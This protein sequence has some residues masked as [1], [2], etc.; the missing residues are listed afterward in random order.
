MGAVRYDIKQG[1]IDDLMTVSQDTGY[2]TS[3]LNAVTIEK[4]PSDIKEHQTPLV[5]VLDDEREIK[6]VQA[7]GQRLYTWDL[8]LTCWVKTNKAADV[9]EELENLIDSV[10]EWTRNVVL[11]DIHSKVLDIKFNKI[12]GV[13][14]EDRLKLGGAHLLITVTYYEGTQAYSDGSVYG[15]DIFDATRVKI[16][17]LLNDLTTSMSGS[18][19]PHFEE[20]IPQHNAVITDLNAVSVDLDSYNNM[21][22]GLDEGVRTRYNMS[23]SI[24]I[25]TAY[26][27][28]VVDSL[29]NTRLMDSVNSYLNTH[30]ELDADSNWD[31]DIVN[32]GSNR[33]EFIESF[34]TG[35]E[36]IVEITKTICHTQE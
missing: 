14:H 15:T 35:S 2:A 3:I 33:T 7:N 21:P 30:K 6:Q 10:K 29:T 27:G 22:S 19:A 25:H 16:K 23:W 28:G 18:T 4:N 12:N 13:M 26:M 20:V 32:G 1:I 31:I 34:T 5:C 24:R 17:A 11:S 36:L 9:D 8:R